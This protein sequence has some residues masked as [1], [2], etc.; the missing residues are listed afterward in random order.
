MSSDAGSIPAAS[1]KKMNKMKSNL[2]KKAV[3]VLFLFFF[4]SVLFLSA[5]TEEELPLI[6]LS[7][8]DHPE[9][10]RVAI[11]VPVPLDSNVEKNGAFLIVK[12]TPEDEYRTQRR[13]PSSQFVESVEWSKGTEFYALVIKN[14]H[15]RFTFETFTVDE[16]PQIVIDIYPQ[17]EEVEEDVF[18]EKRDDAEISRRRRRQESFFSQGMPAIVIDPGH[19]GMDI[20]AQG[21]FG[22]YEKDITLSI[23]LKL[24]NII[25]KNQAFLV[26]LT[27][28]ED[29]DK[30]LDDRAATANN[31]KPSCLN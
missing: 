24:K 8:I 1:T 2:L 23:S 26:H 31:N 14:K 9:Y 29:I 19:G 4:S 3:F 25:E 11:S 12:I 13:V 10:S 18:R 15:S 6:G 28:D 30:S 27:R 16:P 20:G 5:Q 21:E 17:E 22:T 7:V